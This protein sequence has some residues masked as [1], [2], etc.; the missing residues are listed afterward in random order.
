MYDLTLVQLS[1]P[2][3]GDEGVWQLR[4]GEYV[5]GYLV[6]TTDA[7]A[8]IWDGLKLLATANQVSHGWEPEIVYRAP[9]DVREVK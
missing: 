6:A 8:T 7:F 2:Q 5:V 3:D 1:Q 4:D 9:D